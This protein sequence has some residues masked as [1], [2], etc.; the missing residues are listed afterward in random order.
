M[1]SKVENSP[2]DL[3]TWKSLA[4]LTNVFWWSAGSKSLTEIFLG[5]RLAGWKKKKAD[6][7]LEEFCSKWEQRKFF[8]NRDV[9]IRLER[10]RRSR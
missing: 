8:R 5:D 3:A 10:E 1:G 7:F 9:K 4:T 2:P 6:N